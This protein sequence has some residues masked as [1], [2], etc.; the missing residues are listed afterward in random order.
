MGKLDD[1][2]RSLKDLAYRLTLEGKRTAT[3]TRL[4]MELT[5]LD[6]RRKELFARLGERVNELRL[7]GQVSDAGLISLL[8]VEF[9]DLDRVAKH[10]LE[11]MDAIQQ[12]HL[13]GPEESERMEPDE[14]PAGRSENLIDSFDVL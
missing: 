14:E 12:I 10:I 9:D 5:G 1:L 6:R 11:T 8:Q 13:D 3:V 7:K 2:T 4:R